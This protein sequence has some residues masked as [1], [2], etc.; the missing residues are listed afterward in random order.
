MSFIDDPILCRGVLWSARQIAKE[1]PDIV[2]SYVPHII[3]LLGST[4]STI[5]GHA[6]WVLGALADPDA[7][8]ELIKLQGDA[9][10]LYIYDQGE[11]KQTAVGDLAA[12]SIAELQKRPLL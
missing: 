7:I 8:K 12:N 9:S 11:L 6:A 4:D 1:R 2:R 10:P 3:K 5:R